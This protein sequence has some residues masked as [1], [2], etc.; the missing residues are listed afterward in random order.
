MQGDIIQ[1]TLLNE[2]YRKVLTTTSNMQLVVMCLQP[3]E[4]IGMEVHPETTQFFHIVSGVTIGVV[5][6]VVYGLSSGEYLVVPPGAN[7]NIINPSPGEKLKLYTIYTPP[8]HPRGT[9]QKTKPL[10][11]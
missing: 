3:G 2:N 6:E 10:D 11:E 1:E 8:E 4:E 5:D 7:H 9:V